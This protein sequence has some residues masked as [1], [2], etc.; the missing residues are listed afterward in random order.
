MRREN[1]ELELQREGSASGPPEVKSV[2]RS[3]YSRNL[4]DGAISDNDSRRMEIAALLAA[5][6]KQLIG[7]AP[8]LEVVG[9]KKTLE[10]TLLE[11]P[12]IEN[13]ANAQMRFMQEQELSSIL[14]SARITLGLVERVPKV[15][16]KGAKSTLVIPPD[17]DDEEKP[18][19]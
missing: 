6:N 18:P 5:A 15:K 3:T 2:G 10:D 1:K 12:L 17:W 14:E 9:L 16:G 19:N 13:T 11:L 4:G 8:D 7:D